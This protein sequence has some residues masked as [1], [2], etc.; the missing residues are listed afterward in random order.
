MAERDGDGFPAARAPLVK[1][2]HL[3]VWCRFLLES[4]KVVPIDTLRGSNNNNSNQRE[5]ALVTDRTTTIFIRWM[6]PTRRL[7]TIG[8]ETARVRIHWE[9]WKALAFQRHKRLL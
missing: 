3:R 8:L 6:P 7:D 2:L 5:A 9:P 1:C 4:K